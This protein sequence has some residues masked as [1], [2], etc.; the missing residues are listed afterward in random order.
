MEVRVG[1]LTIEVVGAASPKF[2][3][4][5]LLVHGLWSTAAMWRRYTGF[6]AHRGW[7]CHAVNLRGRCGA[8]S[9]TQLLDYQD[10]V[11]RAISAMHPAPVIV[12]HDLGGLLALRAAR[13]ACAVVALTPLVSWPHAAVRGSQRLAMMTG[14]PVPAPRG[15][16]GHAYFGDPALPHVVE[17]AT[18]LRELARN[19]RALTA[20]APPTLIVAGGRDP[21]VATATAQTL[22]Q[23]IGAT[24]HVDQ[25]AG[26]ALP[27]E[28]GWERRVGDMHRWL[29]Q[30]L[31]D[32]L[33]ALREE[34]EQ[35]D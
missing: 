2:T 35:E 15:R 14:R 4:P 22:A 17:P 25:H 18:L 6:L 33:L 12:G 16:R 19:E 21:F 1:D 32:P 8:P 23:R 34:S 10:D 13:D 24:F 29:I 30:Q 9:A 27:V 3:A 20:P 26:H 31:G 5:L 7:L 11:E 28:A